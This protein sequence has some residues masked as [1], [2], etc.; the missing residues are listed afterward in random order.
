MERSDF[1]FSSDISGSTSSNCCS[2][3]DFNG[4]EQQRI[5]AWLT[6]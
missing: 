3:V 1:A 4:C 6:K 5:I 2:T